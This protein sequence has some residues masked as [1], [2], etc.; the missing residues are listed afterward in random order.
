MHQ[1]SKCRRC[2]D[3]D[4]TINHIISECSKLAEK[5]YKAK[6]DGVGKVIHREMCK[7]YKDDYANKLYTHNPAPVLVNDAQK[8]RWDFDIQTDYLISARRPDFIISTKNKNKQKSA[9]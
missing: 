7:K 5:R 8:L 1:N 9:K 2:G 6:N 3:K 4:E